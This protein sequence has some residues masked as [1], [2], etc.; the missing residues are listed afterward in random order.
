MGFLG[1]IFSI[2]AVSALWGSTNPLIKKFSAKIDR[3][4]STTS[5]NRFL[6]E[7]KYL[8]TNWEC[9][10][11]FLV[12]QS[13]SVLYFLTLQN[14]DLSLVVPTTNALTLIFT[15]TVGTFLGEETP[16]IKTLGGIGLVLTG[17]IFCI[18]DKISQEE[19]EQ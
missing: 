17:I 13:G 16:N 7:I 2:L 14:A 10:L 5:V 8:I 9:L 3:V 11:L 19:L 18:L 6:N 15:G 12:N 1:N 4:P